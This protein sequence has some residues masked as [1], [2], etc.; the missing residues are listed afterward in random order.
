MLNLRYVFPFLVVCC[1]VVTDIL[2]AQG[3]R[4]RRLSGSPSQSVRQ[5]TSVRPSASSAPLTAGNA[6]T[7]ALDPRS[8]EV[9]H[10]KGNHLIRRLSLL[11]G[12]PETKNLQIAFVID[13][14]DSMGMEL[15]GVK[16][17][18]LEIVSK[19]QSIQQTEQTISLSLVVYRDVGVASKG[20]IVLMPSKD[21]TQDYEAFQNVVAGIKVATGVP[22]F[23]EAVDLGVYQAIHEL[24]W[25]VDEHTE[26]WI[27]LIGDAPPFPEGFNERSTGAKRFHP[28]EILIRDAKEKGI[29]I[30]GIICSS[31]FIQTDT[32]SQ[33]QLQAIYQKLLPETREFFNSLYKGTSGCTMIDLSDELTQKT[34]LALFKDPPQLKIMPISLADVETKRNEIAQFATSDPIKVVVSPFSFINQSDANVVKMENLPNDEWV[35]IAVPL[36]DALQHIPSVTVAD[37]YNVQYRTVSYANAQPTIKFNTTDNLK[38]FDD[39]EWFVQGDIQRRGNL[40]R[41]RVSLIH[42]D[43][44]DKPAATYVYSGSLQSDTPKN[45]F[46][47]LISDLREKHPN[48]NLIKA[49]E[50][51]DESQNIWTQY[52]SDVR[53]RRSIAQAIMAMECAVGLFNDELE[54]SKKVMELMKQAE[55]YL[56]AALE[57]EPNN[58]YAHSLLANCYFNQIDETSVIDQIVNESQDINEMERNNARLRQKVIEHAQKADA[59][60]E[61]C[62]HPL[63]KAE[64][65]A[66]YALFNGDFATAIKRYQELTRSLKHER[67]RIFAV[68]A[69]WALA[70]IFAGDWGADQFID[71]T[72]ARDSIID[73]LAIDESSQQGMFFRRMLE[74]DDTNGTKHPYI[75]KAYYTFAPTRAT[76]ITE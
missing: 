45:I 11:D 54:Y 46:Q 3:N 68:R 53:V 50:M 38:N 28:T 44:P 15:D 16:Q 37:F 41:I 13:G 56:L 59:N 60:K 30:S 20:G 8:N 35:A 2:P 58:P 65:E 34:L 63:I 40:D 24:A 33:R 18:A 31:G 1:F 26:R 9:K 66:D 69:H 39:A 22:Y 76:G 74:W 4:T 23:P 57:W 55:N 5:E 10:A 62:Y 6:L 52:S 43:D 61:L 48:A 71:A 19:V 47:N 36:R 51:I 32:S 7:F 49:Y 72:V 42:R 17:V 73:I 67:D 70:G 12:V 75:R 25:T 29:K 14:T 21:F 27:I 64:I